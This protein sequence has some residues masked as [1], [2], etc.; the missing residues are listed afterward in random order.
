M[1]TGL[2]VIQFGDLYRGDW[3]FDWDNPTATTFKAALFGTKTINF[4]V[5]LLYNQAPLDTGQQATTGAYVAGGMS[6]PGRS[7]AETAALSAT[8]AFTATFMEWNPITTSSVS[9]VA[10]YKVTDNKVV[11]IWDLGTPANVTNGIFRVTF[12]LD[13]MV[14][15][16]LIP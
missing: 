8:L 6:V 3:V 15:H 12:A 7:V 5:A 10:I 4:S 2:S 13:R 14:T 16:R 11:G 1:P 9:N